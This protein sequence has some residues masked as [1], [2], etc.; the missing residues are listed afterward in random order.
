MGLA[1]EVV[2]TVENKVDSTD[3]VGVVVEEAG[4]V[5]EVDSAVDDVVNSAVDDE[6]DS[7]VDDKD[8]LVVD[9]V[10]D[11]AVDDA[12]DWDSDDEDDELD[13]GGTTGG[14]PGLG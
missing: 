14:M 5:V 8:D 2:W 6:V 11:L 9:D 4:W 13:A 12:V 3:E 10:V 1:M 7:A